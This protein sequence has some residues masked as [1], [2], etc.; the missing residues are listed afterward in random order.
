MSNVV[1]AAD[2]VVLAEKMNC[3]SQRLLEGNVG[4]K[5]SGHIMTWKGSVK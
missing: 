1:V 3:L 5:D 2:I 4:I